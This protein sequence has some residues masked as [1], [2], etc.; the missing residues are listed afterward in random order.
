MSYK[1]R[2]LFPYYNILRFYYFKK[3]LQSVPKTWQVLKSKKNFFLKDVQIPISRC[4]FFF[5]VVFF[6]VFTGTIYGWKYRFP[7]IFFPKSRNTVLK[8]FISRP[9][10]NTMPPPSPSPLTPNVILL[11]EVQKKIQKNITR[12]SKTEKGKL[13]LLSKNAVCRSKKSWY[14]EE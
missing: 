1:N 14:I 4:F 3:S 2:L 8:I 7:T 10:V 11:F 6:S 13:M 9:L 12:L 5:V